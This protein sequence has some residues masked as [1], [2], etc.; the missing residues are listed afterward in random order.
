MQLRHFFIA[1]FAAEI[2]LAGAN[3]YIGVL[4]EH[5]QDGLEQEQASYFQTYKLADELR[6]SS[7]YLTRFARKFTVTKDESLVKYY[8]QIL[9]IRDGKLAAP[10]GYNSVYWDLVTGKLIAEPALSSRGAQS[11]EDRL[12]QTGI[13][14]REFNLLKDAKIRSD[15]LAELELR[16]MHAAKGEF[17]DG[18]GKYTRKGAPDQAT[19]IRLLNDENYS[20]GKAAIMKPVADFL[21]AVDT[22]HKLT[23]ETLNG[24][25]D[26]LVRANTV[27]AVLFVLS[28]IAAAA[29]LL[30]RFLR[31]GARLMAAVE[32]IGEGALTRK[33]GVTGSDEIGRLGGAIDTMADRLHAA[34]TRLEDKVR[35]VEETSSELQQERDRSDKLLR[36]I[37]PAVIAARLQNGEEMIAETYPEVTVLFADIVGF[38]GLAAKL[39]PYE[40]VRMLNDIFGRFDE[41]VES[42]QLEKIK[43][44]G[45]CYMVVGGVPDRTPLHCQRI[46]QF[47]LEAIKTVD[48][49][50]KTFPMPLQIRIGVHTGT[51]VAGVVGKRKF[52]YD[53]WGEVVNMA[54][55]YQSTGQPNKIHVSDAVHLR[56]ADDFAFEDAGH[57]ELKG[58]GAEHSW[59]LIGERAASAE[60]IELRKRRA[61]SD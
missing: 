6:A 32:A 26:Q 60:V 43:T 29:V 22:R 49:Y 53:L 4:L 1:F 18:E 58:H 34:F 37:L 17:E 54:S 38:T 8:Q 45:D 28:I 44:I 30:F 13:T 25:S 46:A 12:L 36:N 21:D 24:R 7:E 51:V 42:Y 52:S 2:A 47:A 9:D 3:L 50:S 27:V 41:L 40:T 39:G 57:V 16:A 59:F 14:A 15:K 20:K 56:L 35:T 23:L 19:A 11:L 61:M 5:I 33:T 48:A 10:A 31:R 55:R